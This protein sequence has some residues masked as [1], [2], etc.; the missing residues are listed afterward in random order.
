[1]T[2]KKRKKDKSHKDTVMSTNYER[3]TNTEL[4]QLLHERMPA[5]GFMS[6]SSENRKTVIAMLVISERTE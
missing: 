1:M 5:M 4:Q 3:L 6:V 2:A